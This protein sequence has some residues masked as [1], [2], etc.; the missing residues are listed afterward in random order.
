MRGWMSHLSSITGHLRKMAV[1]GFN[2]TVGN[3]PWAWVPDTESQLL[4][5]G[6]PELMMEERKAELER[7]RWTDLSQYAERMAYNYRRHLSDTEMR[8]PDEEIGG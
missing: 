1:D 3:V 5:D 2:K 8:E 7:G 6:A 4:R